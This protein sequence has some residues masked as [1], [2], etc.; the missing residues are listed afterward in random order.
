MTTERISVTRVD[1]T[2]TST[3][4]VAAEGLPISVAFGCS[5]S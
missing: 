1:A 2:S 5:R 4:N 3:K